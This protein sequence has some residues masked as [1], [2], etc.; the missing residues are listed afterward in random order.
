MKKPTLS[1]RFRYAF[2]NIMSRGT[3]ALIAWL[4]AV[5][6]IMIL[7][8]AL[9][10]QVSGLSPADDK[11]NVKSFGELAWMGLMRTLDAGTMGG[12]E[13]DMGFL[14]FMLA[15]TLGG[16]FVV[17]TLIGILTSGIE[18]KL[19]ELRKGRSVVLE[20]GHTV[21]LGWS[22]HVFYIISEL[23]IAN[24]NKSRSCIVVLADK[25]KVEMEDEIRSRI[26]KTGRTRVICRS[27]SP[28]DMADLE[29]ARPETA[30]SVIIL[31]PEA[32]DPDAHVIKSL[33]AVKNLPGRNP[34]GRIVAEIRN[35]KN[36]SVAKMVGEKTAD[37]ILVPELISRI[38]IQ[39]S[40]EPGLSL[41]FTELLDFGGDEIYFADEPKLVGR[42]FGEVLLAYEDSSIIGLRFPDGRTQLNPP[43]DLRIAKGD[44]LIAISEDDDTI[45]LSGKDTPPVD[46]AAIRNVPRPPA[47]PERALVLGW[48]TKALT[49]I[50]EMDHYVAPGSKVLVVADQEGL[51]AVV[52]SHTGDFKN[53]TIEVR[54]GDTTDRVVLDALEIPTYD[55]VITVSYAESMNVQE[56]DARTLITLL[57][58][59]DIATKTGKNFSIVSE[60]LDVRNREL[61]QVTRANDFIV[62]DR[63][64][65]LLMSQISENHELA[66]VFED[67]FDAGGSELHNRPAA[68]YVELGKPV[69][70]YTVVESARRR[71]EIAVGYKLK[72]EETDD[73]KNFGVYTN[74]E[75]SPK[76]TFSADDRIVVLAEN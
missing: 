26:P 50:R 34:E 52:G 60:M 10:V 23:I 19:D 37:I 32:T 12:D 2:D 36:L 39:A 45:V 70:F 72:S 67:L 46:G 3:V 56:A 48:N 31:A 35:Q 44:R 17:S 28:I 49:M 51:E 59:R 53:Q 1:Q 57:H 54:Q 76:I 9:A 11:G 68:E 22:P 24:E 38:T 75:K 58:L 61:A 55:R 64:V 63:I 25:D 29:M 69:T 27:G 14:L 20:S 18:A 30:K 8:I 71:G 73:T 40:R 33:L 74:P 5:S 42:T 47:K 21:I 6:A 4:F 65:S 43:M 62:S 13:G 7:A 16:V 15:I 41:V 66:A